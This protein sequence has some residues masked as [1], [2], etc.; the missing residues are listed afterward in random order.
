M[1]VVL[2]A[3]YEIGDLDRFLEVFDGFAP[4][5]RAAGALTAGLARSLDD[6]GTVVAT[7]GFTTREQ[8]AAFA[9][10]PERAEA[11]RAAGVTAR[12]DELLG[13]LRPPAP[14]AD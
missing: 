6:P 13:E 5:R 7:I 4:Q 12:R 1:A 8:A 10:S 9:T 2:L 11:L 3:H 14:A